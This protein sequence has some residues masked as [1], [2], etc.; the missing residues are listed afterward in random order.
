[1]NLARQVKSD[2]QSTGS[3]GARRSQ[4]SSPRAG[5]LRHRGSRRRAETEREGMAVNL[6]LDAKGERGAVD[7]EIP[8]SGYRGN[9]LGD[10]RDRRTHVPGRSNAD[11]KR[12]DARQIGDL[13]RKQPALYQTAIVERGRGNHIELSP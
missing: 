5:A 2:E 10:Q 1:M 6:L 7:A 12:I 9:H 11:R 4:E 8:G 3:I 13:A